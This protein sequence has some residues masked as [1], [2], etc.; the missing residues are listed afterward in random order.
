MKPLLLFTSLQITGHTLFE[1]SVYWHRQQD[2]VPGRLQEEEEEEAHSRQGKGS[3]CSP[4]ATG[5][6]PCC[7]GPLGVS[8][9]TKRD[10]EVVRA[11][12]TS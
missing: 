9:P 8:K 6:V 1:P 11:E 7:F 12:Q 3:C 5:D 4:E 10:A 2:K